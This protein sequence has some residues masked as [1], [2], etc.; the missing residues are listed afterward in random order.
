[1]NRFISGIAAAGCLLLAGCGEDAAEQE[2][3]SAAGTPA[4]VAATPAPDPVVSE[5][6]TCAAE[7]GITYLCGL[8]N[9]EDLLAVGDSG[10]LLASGMSRGNISGHLYLVDPEQETFRELIF[11]GGFSAELDAE[12]Y[13]QCQ[14][15]LPLS[16]FSIHGLSLE[17]NEPMRFDLYVTSHG[18]REAIEI[19]DLDM[20]GEEPALT[21]KGCVPLPENT[22][23]NSVA[24]LDDGGFVTTKMMDPREGFA[25]INAGEIS[26]LVYEWHP[27]GEVT[28]VEGTELSGANGIVLSEDDRY[29]YVAAMGSREVVKF[30]RTMNPISK[31]SVTIDIVPD[32]IRWGEEG[33]LLAAGN[34]YAPPSECSGPDCSTGWSIVEVDAD[35]LEARRVAGFGPDV[36]IQGVSSALLMDDEFWVGTF[37][38]DRVGRFPRP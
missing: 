4:D 37:N 28:A 26:G 17:E 31:E 38:G 36:S 35:T 7:E 6:E 27:G 18:S 16:N 10:L 8:Q 9:A 29:M 33:T 15:I 2:A 12:T 25:P 19:F 20:S 22:F 21:W 13:P 30:D 1:M 23:A 24:I 11:G 34:N 14:G 3:A 32:N 5:A